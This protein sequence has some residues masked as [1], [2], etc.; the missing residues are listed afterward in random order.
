A[1]RGRVQ[2]VAFGPGGTVLS[3]GED[4]LLRIWDPAR[5]TVVASLAG[6]AA[7]PSAILPL[8]PSRILVASLDR[9]VRVWDLRTRTVSGVVRVDGPITAAIAAP[10][11]ASVWVAT[12]SAVHEL[13]ALRPA[14]APYVL[15]RPV[16]AAEVASLDSAFVQRLQGARQSL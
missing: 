10:S 13:R 1:D 16:S 6:P 7:T 3:A 4:R 12:G 14:R 5:A 8:T 9:T 15:A 2:A 11:A